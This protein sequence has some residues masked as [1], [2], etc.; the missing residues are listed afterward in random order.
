MCSDWKSKENP[1]HEIIPGI[2]EG[3]EHSTRAGD[4][5]ELEKH[6]SN[7]IT[8][9]TPLGVPLK[10]STGSLQTFSQRKPM[11]VTRGEA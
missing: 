10:R 11:T 8:L 6:P 5:L 4:L 3:C 1:V 2:P 9:Q 7:R